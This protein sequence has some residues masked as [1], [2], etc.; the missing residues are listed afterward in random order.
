MTKKDSIK[1]LLLTAICVAAFVGFFYIALCCPMVGVY[2]MIF[3]AVY[4]RINNAYQK[5]K[6]KDKKEEP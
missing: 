3:F 1:V 5:R 6:E 4:P 2:G